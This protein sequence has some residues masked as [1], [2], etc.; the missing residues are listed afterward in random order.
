M[1]STC[2]SVGIVTPTFNQA[3]FLEETVKSV[4][5]QDHPHIHYVVVNDGSSDDTVRVASRLEGK[6]DFVDQQNKGQA[7]TLNEQWSKLNTDYLTYLSSDDLLAPDA[8]SKAAAILD[9]DS[10]I[11]CVFPDYHVVDKSGRIIRRSVGQ[12]FDLEKSIVTQRCHIGPGPVFRKS[13]F[14]SVGGWRPEMKLAPDW[15]FWIRLSRLGQ[16]RFLQEPLAF[17]RLHTGSFSA[18]DVS[19]ERALEFVN[20]LDS[21]FGDNPDDA[22]QARRSEAYANAYSTVARNAFR[23]GDFREGAQ[24]LRLAKSLD[25]RATS[26]RALLKLGRNIV[27]KPLQLAAGKIRSKFA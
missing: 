17:Y 3:D 5:R 7:A 18:T 1:T 13:A 8:I 12:P 25:R 19:K 26:P 4:L 22:I 10:S 24:Y 11:V 2:A 15:E 9:A 16:I 6:L 21:Y 27:S 14:A 23:R 20:V